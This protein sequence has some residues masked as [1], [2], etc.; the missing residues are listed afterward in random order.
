[1]RL[2]H[3]KLIEHLPGKQLLGQ[4]RECCALRGLGWGKPHSVVNYVFKHPYINLY[5]YHL[6]VISE[7]IHRGYNVDSKWLDKEFRGKTRGYDNSEFTQN[8]NQL[9]IKPTNYII[10]PEHNYEYLIEC[11]NNLINKGIDISYIL[12]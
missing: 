11:L 10:Y 8:V 1:M 6:R 4:H 7:M 12:D 9:I 5:E 3:Q 2:W